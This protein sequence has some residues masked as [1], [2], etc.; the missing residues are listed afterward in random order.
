[1]K[2]FAVLALASLA[3]FSL[4]LACGSDNPEPKTPTPLPAV[5][6][7]AAPVAHDRDLN[8]NPARISISEDIRSACGIDSADAHFAFDES[9]VRT[10]DSV[11]LDKLVTC[12]STGALN[13][14]QMRLVGHTD[15]RGDEDYNYVLGERRANAVKRYLTRGGLSASQATTTSRGELEATGTNETSWAQDRRVDVMLAE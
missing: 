8:S 7:L 11:V 2:S 9:A 14:R 6:T 12:F 1:M 13:G 3:S 5:A 4:S 15:D 10:Q